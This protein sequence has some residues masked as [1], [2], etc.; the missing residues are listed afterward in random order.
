MRGNKFMKHPK[1]MF[2]LGTFLGVGIALSMSANADRLSRF[3]ELAQQKGAQWGVNPNLIRAIVSVESAGRLN[4]VS[5]KGAQGV[6]QLM[7]ATAER[8]GVPRSQL[9]DPERNMEAGVRYLSFLNKRYNGNATLVA[10]GYNAGEGAVD[11]YGGVPPYRETQ[12]YAP[13]V[14]ARMK[15]LDACG[16]ACYTHEHMTNPQRYLNSYTTGQTTVQYASSSI[17]QYSNPLLVWGNSKATLVRPQ[18]Q[19]PVAVQPVYRATTQAVQVR[20][21]QVQ[22]PHPVKPKRHHTETFVQTLTSDGTYSV[23]N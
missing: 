14:V 13:A 5:P 8:M 10:A 2:G 21:V 17:M 12:N 23:Q 15:L 16:D 19:Q 6:M 9:F 7:P 20:A 3:N 18:A 4:A 22:T 11:K 1:I